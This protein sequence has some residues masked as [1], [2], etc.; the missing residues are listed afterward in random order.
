MTEN[1]KGLFS[2]KPPEEEPKGNLD[3]A[4]E[5][6]ETGNY[7]AWNSLR[8]NAGKQSRLDIKKASNT[9][10]I[11]YYPYISTIEYSLSKDHG[12]TLLTMIYH[13]QQI[14]LQG[15]FLDKL[16]EA[17]QD[18]RVKYIQEFN[19]VKH[20]NIAADQPIIEKITFV[21]PDDHE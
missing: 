3:S 1:E 17:L 4:L 7:H 10:T 21:L 18:E 13:D 5:F 8:I 20:T 12:L 9:G 15:K 16:K 2:D 14:M 6:T 19:P 11:I